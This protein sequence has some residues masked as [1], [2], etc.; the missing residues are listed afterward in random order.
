[1]NDSGL[2]FK[3]FTHLFLSV[4]LILSASFSLSAGEITDRAVYWGTVA[5][6]M[7][8]AYTAVTGDLGG[9]SYN[10]AAT[11]TVGGGQFITDYNQLSINS[12]DINNI[13]VGGSYR[14][15]R[16]I[17]G[18]VLHR[19]ALDF[20]FDNFQHSSAGLAL[21]YS[22]DIYYYNLVWNL[23][24]NMHVG[25]NLKYYSL[26]TDVSDGNA[27]GY[28]VDFGLIYLHEDW[29]TLGASVK[30]FI[31]EKDWDSG[32]SEDLP[33]EARVGVRLHPSADFAWNLDLAYGEDPGLQSVNAG[34]EWWVWRAEETAPVSYR[35]PYF[36]GRRHRPREGLDYGVALRAGAEKELLGDE[37][38]VISAG[39]GMQFGRGQLD[40]SYRQRSDFDNQHFFGFSA[41]FGGQA[42]D[43]Y[44]QPWEA[45]E[46][47][48][49]ADETPVE[50]AAEELSVSGQTVGF[51]QWLTPTDVEFPAEKLA[52]RL[53]AQGLQQTTVF[54]PREQLQSALV[55]Q[56]MTPAQI[57]QLLEAVGKELLISGRVRRQDGEFL[58]D[59]HLFGRYE[60]SSFTV[61][62]STLEELADKL[63]RHLLETF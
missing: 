40:Y 15:G 37:E 48:E 39:V 17:H 29:L 23:T 56:Q 35:E 7:G 3:F 25:T 9:I 38:L 44:D 41:T 53:A 8:G 20:N 57:Q 22:D 50:E 32:T 14:F 61:R 1:M 33:L 55:D 63:A 62:G 19:T 24:R 45:L 4:V 43:Q 47:A 52:S 27:S 49:S 46:E 12:L 36:W 34:G 58:A 28:G 26:S 30:N 42:E 5:Q 21:D 59:A 2:N 10:P 18:L 16:F 60:V 13:T 51:L 6:G 11:A 31:A 54:E